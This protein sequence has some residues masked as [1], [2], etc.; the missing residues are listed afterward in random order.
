VKRLQVKAHADAHVEAAQEIRD[1]QTLA[2]RALQLGQ[3]CY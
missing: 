1:R 2:A 3:Y